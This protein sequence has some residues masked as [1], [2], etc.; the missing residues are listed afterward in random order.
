[1]SYSPRRHGFGIA[2]RVLNTNDVQREARPTH[3]DIM[4]REAQK[5]NTQNRGAPLSHGEM[6]PAGISTKVRNQ[7]PR[8]SIIAHDDRSTM[9]DTLAAANGVSRPQ[10]FPA[11]Q[12]AKPQ[13]RSSKALRP[14][15]TPLFVPQLDPQPKQRL[16]TISDEAL[17]QLHRPDQRRE[18][19]AAEMAAG[20]E[21]SPISGLHRGDA[22]GV[23]ALHGRRRLPELSEQ[24]MQE[25]DRPTGRLHIP[26]ASHIVL[27]Q[28][29]VAPVICGRRRGDPTPTKASVY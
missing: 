12:N 3:D 18:L 5:Y 19:L 26:C 28:E 22:H 10:D 24:A 1:M 23:N 7:E 8:R 9:K 21:K 11:M 20:G 15:D 27:S 6:P 29:I 25:G 4:D 16:H 17:R 13:G 14:A 2:T